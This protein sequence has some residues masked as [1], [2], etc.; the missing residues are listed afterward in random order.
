[1]DRV[2]LTKFIRDKF[3]D[4]ELRDLCFELDIDYES[5]GGEGKAA[6]AR[7]LVAFCERRDRL[8]ELERAAQQMSAAFSRGTAA[9]RPTPS[10]FNQSGQIVHGNQINVQGD[11]MDHSV[12]N[13]NAGRE[14]PGQANPVIDEQAQERASLQRQLVNARENLRLIEENESE[15]VVRASVPPQLIKDERYWRDRIEY[16]ETKLGG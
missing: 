9:P 15:Y 16:L 6:K 11:Y 4:S 12:T 5:L 3:N 14:P 10:V 2:E 13:L 8:P 1:M 7:E